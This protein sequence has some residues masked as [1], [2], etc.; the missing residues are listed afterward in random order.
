MALPGQREDDPI[1]PPWPLHRRLA[2]RAFDVAVS[3]VGLVVV[4]APLLLAAAAVR[5]DSTGPAL[6][7]QRRVG[8]GGRVFRIWKLRTMV[9]GAEAHGPSLTGADDARVTPLGRLLRRS[10][11][12]ELPQLVNVL[13]GDMSLV[14]PRPEVPRYV[15][16][17]PDE[18][19]PVLAV[20]PGITDPASI[21]FCDEAA[22]LARFPD[23]ERAYAEVLLP[24]KLDL[25]RRYLESQTF[26]GDLSLL[27]RT[28]NVIARPPST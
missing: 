28:L 8:R 15:A 27:L 25:S 7:R 16:R 20:R 22:A 2:K 21:E 24:R 4:G 1:R 9:A 5:I 14:G 17:F 6:F 26:F 11:I 3:S 18:F 19:R 13:V 10:K 23:A 12:D